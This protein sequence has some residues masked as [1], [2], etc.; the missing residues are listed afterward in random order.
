MPCLFMNPLISLIAAIATGVAAY[1]AYRSAKMSEIANKA[2]FSPLLIPTEIY[3]QEAEPFNP[4][5][6]FIRLDN[7]TEYKNAYAKN[8]YAEVNGERLMRDDIKPGSYHH[9]RWD[10]TVKIT[11]GQIT[12]YYE[13][14]LSNKFET[15]CLL[16]GEAPG[17]KV[18]F[19]W[20]YYQK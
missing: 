19:G 5:H 13:D 9:F 8:I 15:K 16:Q 17:N 7:S 10:N 3:Y 6:F 12:F 2:Q 4:S 18:L 20:R 14:I 1:F 11:T